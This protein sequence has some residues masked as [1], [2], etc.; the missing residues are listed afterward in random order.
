MELVSKDETDEGMHVSA[1]SRGVSGSGQYSG[2]KVM[3]VSFFCVEGNQLISKG[4]Y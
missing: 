4:G 2:D 1:I 3:C